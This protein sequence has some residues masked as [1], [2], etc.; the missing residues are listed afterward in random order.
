M[1]LFGKKKFSSPEEEIAFLRTEI[2]RR[3]REVL[4]RNKGIDVA[5]QETIGKAVMREYAEHDPTILLEKKHIL[6]PHAVAE[7]YGSLEVAT[8]KVEEMI[9]LAHEKGIRN[10]LSVLEKMQDAYLTDE[11]HRELVNM[12]REGRTVADLKENMPLWKMLTMTLFEVA[13]PRHAD[14]SHAQDIKT[15]FFAMEQFYAGMQTISRG[16]SP[17]YYTLEIAVS[18]KRDDIIFYV[19][20]PN[21]FVNLFEKQALSLFPHAMLVEQQ[22]DYNVFVDQGTHIISTAT[23]KKHPIYPLKTHDQF[24]TDPLAVLLNAFS[25]IERDGGGA[26]IQIVIG[27]GASKYQS[28]YGSIIKRIEKGESADVAIRKSTLGGALFEDL[29]DFVSSGNTKKDDEKPKDIDTEKIELFK[30]KLGA[31]VVETNIRF[32][33]SARTQVRAE[34]IMSEL[35]S[36]FHQFQNTKGNQLSFRRLSGASKQRELKAFSFREYLSSH[37]APLSL[38]E[39]S[40][41]IHFP[42]EGIES[43]P[44]FKQSRAKHAPAPVDMPTYGTL[45]GENDFRNMRRKIYLTPEDR[46]RHF[47]VIGQTGTGKSKLLQNMIVQDIQDGAGVCMIDPHGTDIVEV[48]SAIPPERIDDVIYFDPSNTETSIGLN[49]L[50]YDPRFPEQKTFVVNEL[51]SMFQKLYGA[52]PESMGPMFEQYFRN[53]TLLVLED[54]ASGCTLL[55]ISRVMADSAYRNYKLKKATNPVVKQFWEKIATKAGGESQLENI[56]PYITS[57][58]DP[59]T[60]NDY[61]RPII[62][63]QQSSFNFR[64]IMDTK[65]ILLVNLSKGRLGE[66]NANLIGMIIV[67]KI[68]M[69]ALSR[70]DDLSKSFPPFYLYIDEFQNITTNSISSI[71]SEARKYKLG[72]TVA[73]QFIAQLD[74]GIRDAVFGNV[75]SMAAFRVGKEDAEFLASQFE[76]VF[77]ANDI[78]NI[79]NR[80]AYVKLLS[81]GSPTPPF[82]IKTM[83]THAVNIEYAQQ[84]MEFSALKYGTPRSVVDAEIRARYLA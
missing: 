82:S 70:V 74:A 57:K 15:I 63:Q 37:C 24:N 60:A 53:S 19:A 68:L 27:G 67:G 7:S 83:N 46:L 16:K 2:A 12:L 56:V 14:E 40:T 10:A 48:L 65:K 62:G 66:I 28:Q 64:D 51:F 77:S 79:E 38:M 31:P 75:G 22:N 20:V 42:A 71:L 6:S 34:Q 47:Y 23:L 30:E 1:E 25:K 5:D 4:E 73:H 80:N 84:V 11:V 26:S 35:E 17:L 18:D 21:E 61:M 58:I 45:I 78:S 32:V 36:G 29:K 50:E 8:H 55:D 59:L 41:I 69:A 33:A 81:S 52:N 44:Q 43:S 9:Q 3:E 54:P 49:M 76:P 39:L 13:L 72:L